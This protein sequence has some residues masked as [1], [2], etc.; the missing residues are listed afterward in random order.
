VDTIKKVLVILL[1]LGISLLLLI[2]LFKFNKIDVHELLGDIKSADKW[3][4]LVGFLIFFFIYLLGFLRWKMLLCAAGINIPVRRLI[5]SFSGGAFFSIFLPSTIGGDLVRTAD[6]AG[7]T[8]K[9]KEVI[10]TVFLDRLSGYIGLV[11]VVV[12]VLLLDSSLLSDKIVLSS[13]VLIVAILVFVMFVLFNGFIYSK[14]NRFLSAPGAGK[15]K[16]MIKGLHHEIHIFRHKKKMI[17][18]NIALSFAVQVI[19]PVSV[20]FIAL[21][22]GVKVDF[23]YFLIFLPIIGAVTLLP[24]SLG[25]LGLRE[26]LFVVYFAK[27]GVVKQLAIAMSLLSFAFIVIYGALGGLIYVLTVHNRRVQCYTP[28]Q[29]LKKHT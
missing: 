29:I 1:R 24:V 14:V 5:V 13:V 17:A 12:L 25:G 7:H 28:P 22:L 20:Y 21:S 18:S 16:E 19:A 2:L 15:I 6:L 3:L 27:V 8:K 9:T 23:K 4:L 10:A 26:N 11:I